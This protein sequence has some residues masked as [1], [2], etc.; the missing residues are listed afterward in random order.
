MKSCRVSEDKESSCV[1]LKCKAEH[2][3][4]CPRRFSSFDSFFCCGASAVC[5]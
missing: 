5:T 1:S 4:A 2:N 3:M